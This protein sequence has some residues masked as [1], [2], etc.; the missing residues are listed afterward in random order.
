LEGEEVSDFR[1]VKA[2]EI[3]ADARHFAIGHE[4]FVHE[5]AS[6]IFRGMVDSS[7]DSIPSPDMFVLYSRSDLERLPPCPG[8]YIGFNEH[9]RAQYVGESACVGRRV[10]SFGSRDEIVR[11]KYIAVVLANDERDLRRLEMYYM[12]LLDPVYNKQLHP[13]GKNVVCY[14]E[15]IYWDES[16]RMWS[17]RRKECYIDRN[18]ALHDFR[19]RR[20]RGTRIR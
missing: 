1:L 15:D 14:I 10:G 6:R 9:G 16:R 20:Q 2:S 11:S 7:N 19:T 18:G 3:P 5:D 8:V 12:G 17:F 4:Q 13:R